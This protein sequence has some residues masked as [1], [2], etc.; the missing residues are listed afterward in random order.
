MHVVFEED[1]EPRVIEVPN[2]LQ[3]ALEK[4]GVWEVFDKMPYSHKREY[5]GYVTEAKKEETRCRRIEKTVAF[6][7]DHQRK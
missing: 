4:N 2:D 3:S 5:V 1:I 6:L 7:K